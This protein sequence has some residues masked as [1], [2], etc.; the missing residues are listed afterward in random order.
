M[1]L[2]FAILLFL[3]ST[4][5]S[6]TTPPVNPVIGY[7][8]GWTGDIALFETDAQESR[9]QLKAPAVTGE[10]FIFT[11]SASIENA[12]W[13]IA[14]RMEFNPSSSNYMKV[15]LATDES[16]GFDHGFYLVLGTTDDNISLWQ[17]RSGKDSILVEGVAERLNSSLAE[18]T[19]RVNRTTGGAWLLESD[20]GTGWQTEGSAHSS[21]GFDAGYFGLS[22]HYTSTRSDK[23]FA[24]PITITGKPYADTIPPTVREFDV[25]NSRQI[26]IDV[27][28]PL[29]TLTVRPLTL[30]FSPPAPAVKR[31]T[32]DPSMTRVLLFLE[33]PLPPLE[34]ASLTLSGWRDAAGNAVKDTTLLFSYRPPQITAIS[35]MDYSTLQVC[36]NVEMPSGWLQ[37]HHFTIEGF[38]GNVISVTPEGERCYRLLLDTPLADGTEYD[39]FIENLI[40]PNGDAAPRGPYVLYYHEA[41][42]YDLVMNEV[43]HDPVPPAL[44]PPVEYL[45]LFNR[46]QLPVNLGNMALVINNKRTLLPPHLIFPGEYAVLYSVAD[47]SQA[48]GFV[49]GVAVPQWPG[50]PNSGGEIIVYNPSEKVVTALRYTD[51]LPGEAFKQE[52]GWSME[53]IDPDNLSNDAGN[54]GYSASPNGG[55]PGEANSLFASNPDLLPPSITDAW[56]EDDSTLMLLFSEPMQEVTGPF[57]LSGSSLTIQGIEQETLF[58]DGFRLSFPEALPPHQVY[59]LRMPENLTDLAGNPFKA[60]YDFEFGRPGA[61]DSFDIAINELLYDPPGSGSDYVELYNRSEHIG[62]LAALCI[63]RASM[64]GK[65]EKLNLLSDRRRWF[66]PGQRLCFTPDTAFIQTHYLCEKP[67]HLRPLP[68]LPNFT[69]EGGTVFLT[70]LN[71]QIVDYFNYSP[72]L[73]FP[74]LVNT[75]GVALERTMPHAVTN[76]PSTWHSAAATAGYGTPTGK[77]SQHIEEAMLVSQQLFTVSPD[78][79]T[80]NQDGFLDVL[81]ISY[82]YPEPGNTGTIKIFNTL[83]EVERQLLNNRS[84]G[85]SGQITWD[86]TRDDGSRCPPGI[87]IVWGRVFNLGGRVQEYKTTCVLGTGGLIE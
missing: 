63:S 2:I 73:H 69:N 12:E 44:L 58:Q 57:T 54:R 85:T 30:T 6:Q 42:R 82:D 8:E 23:F 51:T 18:G 25:L 31:I 40:L 11:T 37:P 59:E 17:R 3:S 32:F 62:D 33:S 52:G 46:S 84:L 86:G 41:A 87:Y 26:Q 49:N 80:P 79:F 81:V 21:L 53:I 19:V 47:I 74:L 29:D 10:A 34:N 56:L 61:I 45:E 4:C 14:F 13:L 55:T 66:L 76:Q 75:K 24:G 68:S 48:T 16:P 38:S 22:C 20:T 9:L 50:L 67:H 28:E 64:D 35:V 83:G 27:S 71:G 39:L 7:P 1:R 70:R 65:P 43:M 36:F 72:D 60:S 5:F 15:Y 78:V 77:N